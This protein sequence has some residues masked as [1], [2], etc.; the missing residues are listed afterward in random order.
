MFIVT[1][2]QTSAGGTVS[3]L[4]WSYADRNAAEEQFHRVL[5]AA[6]VSA[7]PK[8][9]ALMYSEEGFPLRHECYKHAVQPETQADGQAEE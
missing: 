5:T 7:L 8:H 1:E 3:T 2:I 4:T 6:A 9:A